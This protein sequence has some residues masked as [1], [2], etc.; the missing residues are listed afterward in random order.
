MKKTLITGKTV[1][2]TGAGTGIGRAIAVRLAELG[3][4]IMV[5][6]LNE[7]TA[8]ETVAM[9]DVS[10]GQKHR[11]MS[12]DVTNK[13]SAEA[14]KE[15]TVEEY[16]KVDI[17]VNNAGVS[18]MNRVENL[19]EQE[20]DFNFDV[21]VKGVFFL[22]QAFLPELKKTKGKIINTASM[23]SLKAAP[24]LSHYTATKYA[25]LGFTK[26]CALELAE[27]E[28]NV[29]CVCP[30]YVKTSMQ[31]REVVW[32]AELRGMQPQEVIDEYISLTPLGRL[33][34]PEDVANVVGFLASPASDYLTG[35]FIPVS[36]GGFSK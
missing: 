15:K 20:W 17:L 30:G 24:L 26:A 36:G 12:V 29:N 35:E 28:I 19:T 16:G 22:T 34:L 27:Y 13:Q 6:D 1:V 3:G 14:A 4:N 23:A 21:N 7:E 11:S 33:C 18:S 10:K 5:T 25:V 9:L 31:E 2:I 32:E 8:K